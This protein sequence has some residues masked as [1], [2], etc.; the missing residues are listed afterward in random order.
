MYWTKTIKTKRGSDGRFLY[1]DALVTGQAR[2]QAAYL[3][4][5]GQQAPP[6]RVHFRHETGGREPSVWV[7][8]NGTARYVKRFADAA[9][10]DAFMHDD[11]VKALQRSGHRMSV[12][13]LDQQERAEDRVY[14]LQIPLDLSD[15]KRLAELFD[16]L[17]R[18]SG[19]DYSEW[20]FSTY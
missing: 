11:D 6:F 5:T 17:G 18:K 10:M 14:E 20:E 12:V 16:K 4:Q 19:L 13:A 8:C 2:A 3:L 9:Q 1:G 15:K 7:D